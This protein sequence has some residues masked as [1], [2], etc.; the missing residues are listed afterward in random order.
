MIDNNN[1]NFDLFE[2]RVPDYT[3]RVRRELGIRDRVD[4]NQKNVRRRVV[5]PLDCKAIQKLYRNNRKKALRIILGENNEFCDLDPEVVA[6]HYCGEPVDEGGDRSYIEYY[7][8]ASGE[9]ACGRFTSKEVLAKLKKCDNTSSGPD[10]ITY[11][12]WRRIDP[13]ARVATAIFN[14]CL[15]FNH[16]PRA[17]KITTTILIYKKGDTLVV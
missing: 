2:N 16:V 6:R 10:G 15:K 3:S 1:F 7:G 11:N 17:W 14:L 8:N 5:D 9:V 13:E 4:P 12:G